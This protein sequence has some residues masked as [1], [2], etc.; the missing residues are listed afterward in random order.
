[1]N[2]PPIHPSQSLYHD[3]YPLSLLEPIPAVMERRQG[4][5]WIFP[6]VA[7]KSFCCL[8]IWSFYH[9]LFGSHLKHWVFIS[10]TWQT[11]LDCSIC[12]AKMWCPPRFC[13]WANTF[14][15]VCSPQWR[16]F[17]KPYWVSFHFY[18]NYS[19]IYFP[20][21]RNVCNELRNYNINS[22]FF[23]HKRGRQ[24]KL[25]CLRCLS[26]AFLLNCS[27]CMTWNTWVNTSHASLVHGASNANKLRFSVEATQGQLSYVTL[28]IETP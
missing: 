16:Q 2:F 20:L 6:S 1:M 9:H 7:F 21:K 25:C 27:C 14:P 17:L 28:H 5:H 10:D 15:P 12:T 4:T 8:T 13:P 3:L 11:F 26:C 19:Q 24:Y 22:L 18:A 23:F